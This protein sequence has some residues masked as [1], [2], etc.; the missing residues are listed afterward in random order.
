MQNPSLA[1]VNTSAR[2]FAEL[3]ATDSHGPLRIEYRWVNEAAADAPIAL[4]LHEGLG[5]V[6]MWRDWPQALCGSRDGLFYGHYGDAT[7][8]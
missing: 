2:D 7:A 5:S 1:A 3:P 6:A 8:L 4:F